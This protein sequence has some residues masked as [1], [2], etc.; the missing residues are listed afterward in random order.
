M[1]DLYLFLHEICRKLVWKFCEIWIFYGNC[2]PDG[3]N[4]VRFY[5]SVR[6]GMYD[7]EFQIGTILGVFFIY[8]PPWYFLPFRVNW[9]FH[10]G[11]VQNRCPRCPLWWPSWISDRN[12]F[13]CLFFLLFFFFVYKSPW[14]FLPSF[15]SNGLLVQEKKFNL[16]F[17]DGR[18]SGHLGFLIGIISAIFYLHVT[19]I[20]PIKFPDI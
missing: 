4:S 1:C 13:S 3:P 15:K 19:P 11:E 2:L 16:D 20:L 17:Q 7:I 18:C 6:Y 9:P 8:K 12:N 14:Y 10:S 5:L